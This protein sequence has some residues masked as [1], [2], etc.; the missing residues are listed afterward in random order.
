MSA[1]VFTSPEPAAD[2]TY[3]MDYALL[4]PVAL[5]E[6]LA[7]SGD[8]ETLGDLLEP[9]LEQ[10][11]WVLGHW[12]NS[13]NTLEAEAG[14]TGFIDWS[15]TLDRTAALQ[16][17]LILSLEACAA[18]CGRAKDEG[19]QALYQTQAE[20]LREAALRHFWSEEE[21]CFLSG[22]QLSIHTQVWLTLSGVMPEGRAGAAFEKALEL[23]GAPRMAT[24]YM[25]HHY[26]M[27]LLKAGL[28]EKAEA[29]LRAYWG[30]MLNAGADTFWECCDP[31]DLQ[32]SPYGGMVVNSFCHAWSCTPAY[33]IDRYLMKEESRP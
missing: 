17:V 23:P 30:A 21:K 7:E 20:R 2:D 32:A 5:E 4:Y 8:A 13:G 11:D 31:D 6:Y 33:I 24:P 28:K 16:G 15:D 3:L 18:L 9:A 27:A 25:H 1:N 26:I 10:A 29:H 22:G 19:R 14:R 12:L